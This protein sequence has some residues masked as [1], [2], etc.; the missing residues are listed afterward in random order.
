MDIE[1]D[2]PLQSEQEEF[3]LELMVHIAE[4]VFFK[5]DELATKADFVTGVG[6]FLA[7]FAEANGERETL[8]SSLNKAWKAI[9]R[10]NRSFQEKYKDQ[11]VH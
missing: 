10:G 3:A 5:E 7:V 9:A 2:L 8:R 1:I 6:M 4:N 11:I